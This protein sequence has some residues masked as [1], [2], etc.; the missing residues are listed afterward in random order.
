[1]AIFISVPYAFCLATAPI[2][3]LDAGFSDAFLDPYIG[4]LCYVLGY[5]AHSACERHPNPCGWPPR[6]CDSRV[7]ATFAAT[8]GCQSPVRRSIAW[9]LRCSLTTK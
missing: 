3:P 4:S 2:A 9:R 1:M 6:T 7:L 8:C 5:D